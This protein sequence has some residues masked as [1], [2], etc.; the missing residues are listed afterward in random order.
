MSSCILKND[1]KQIFERAINHAFNSGTAISELDNGF[2]HIMCIAGLVYNGF[3]EQDELKSFLK[4]YNKRLEQLKVNLIDEVN[5]ATKKSKRLYKDALREIKSKLRYHNLTSA[6]GRI[7]KAECENEWERV[8][9]KNVNLK[10]HLERELK[11]ITVKDIEYGLQKRREIE[12]DRINESVLQ[13]TTND[14]PKLVTS[15]SVKKRCCSKILEPVVTY[16]Y[17]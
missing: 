4:K 15:Y 10:R 16:S 9:T 5:E 6:E 12:R 7:K 13:S 11:K 2:Q 3:I 17:R 1:R 14:K 8:I